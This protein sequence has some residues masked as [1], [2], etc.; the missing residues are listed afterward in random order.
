MLANN[1]NRNT[2]TLKNHD[3]ES[4]LAIASMLGTQARSGFQG[5]SDYTKSDDYQKRSKIIAMLVDAGASMFE[6]DMYGINWYHLFMDSIISQKQ[7]EHGADS[8][9][10]RTDR[11]RQSRTKEENLE[12]VKTVGVHVF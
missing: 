12:Y 5:V 4:A 11:R 9:N 2:V 3:Q 6:K 7:I 1:L 8:G 10:E